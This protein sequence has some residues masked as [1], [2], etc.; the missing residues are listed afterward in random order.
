MVE[1]RC[2]ICF[3]S[4]NGS[5]FKTSCYEEWVD[6][7]IS[8]G[9]QTGARQKLGANKRWSN[10][11]YTY[12]LKPESPVLNNLPWSLQD[13]AEWLSTF[14]VL[15]HILHNDAVCEFTLQVYGRMG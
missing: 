9:H 15:T 7:L 6:H 12:V 13:L 14:G 8:D 5:A 4:G 11:E 10:E 1:F 2:D 3:P